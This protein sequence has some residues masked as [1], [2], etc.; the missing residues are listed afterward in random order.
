MGSVVP[1]EPYSSRDDTPERAR[2]FGTGY[3]E[4][5]RLKPSC[6][7]ANGLQAAGIKG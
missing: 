1:Y 6:L 7:L 4:I 5:A 2:C 3:F